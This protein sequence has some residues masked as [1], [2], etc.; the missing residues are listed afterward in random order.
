MAMLDSILIDLQP[1]SRT[2]AHHPA[3]MGQDG[4]KLRPFEWR[5]RVDRQDGP[6]DGTARAQGT[7]PSAE[8]AHTAESTNLDP[9]DAPRISLARATLRRFMFVCEGT[10]VALNHAR[11]I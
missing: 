6:Q 5:Q 4:R 1:A 3:A 10:T 7:D 2:G 8:L 9:D 11:M